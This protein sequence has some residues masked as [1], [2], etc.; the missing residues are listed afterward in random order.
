MTEQDFCD[1]IG[2]LLKL[3]I[4]DNRSVPGFQQ[5]KNKFHQAKLANE[6]V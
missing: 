2:E 4:M 3:P 1:W 5:Q 6:P